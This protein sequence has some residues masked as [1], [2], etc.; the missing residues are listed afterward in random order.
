MGRLQTLAVI[1]AFPLLLLPGTAGA[2]SPCGSE[3]TVAD[4]ENLADV[5]D[6]CEVSLSALLDANPCHRPLNSP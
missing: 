2:Q 6:R 3:A 1:G 4:G 5:A